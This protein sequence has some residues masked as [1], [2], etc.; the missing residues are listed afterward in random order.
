M[1]AADAFVF[2]AVALTGCGSGTWTDAQLVDTQVLGSSPYPYFA[3]R[4]V[5]GTG[6]QP[7]V[8]YTHQRSTLRGSREDIT[9]STP[10]NIG[11]HTS[12]GRG[13]DVAVL[14][15]GSAM[16]IFTNPG[17]VDLL[18]S[19]HDLGV[20]STPARFPENS[21]ASAPRIVAD[22]FGRALSVW[23]GASG[24]A[25]SARFGGAAWGSPH[26]IGIGDVTS[27][28]LAMSPSGEGI[29]AWCRLTTSGGQIVANR[30]SWATGWDGAT[31]LATVP[32]CHANHSTFDW[33]PDPATV[34]VGITD[35]GVATVLWTDGG[36]ALRRFDPLASSWTP[37]ELVP[38]S[39]SV[40]NV[41]LAVNP[42]GQAIAAWQTDGVGSAL[43]EAAAFSPGSGW[44]D[45]ALVAGHGMRAPRVLTGVDG[46][47]R[48]FVVYLAG[49]TRASRF[50][51]TSF[52]TPELLGEPGDYWM[53][54][55]VAASGEAYL[56]RDFAHTQLFVSRY[57]P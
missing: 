21:G 37:V 5:V 15:N 26:S 51:G 46:S 53:D 55:A 12:P 27:L 39:G 41:S 13:Y 52:L 4:V 43:V 31:L 24:A 3:P 30:F 36:L 33:L 20:W 11:P 38:S 14:G 23:V 45:T 29:A 16:A 22:G 17:A 9:W 48:G 47:G 50:D 42:A 57:D 2:A 54:L 8:V 49:G 1:R 25:R 6:G 28:R 32:V 18:W 40:F 7:T 10:A 34:D 19:Q 35:A 56:A 44:G